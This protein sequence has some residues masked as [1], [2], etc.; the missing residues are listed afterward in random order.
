MDPV[1]NRMASSSS[2]RLLE[3]DVFISFRGP[4][5]RKKFVSHLFKSLSDRGIRTFK[6]D[7]KLEPGDSIAEELCQ[8]IRTSRFAVVVIS[9]TYADSSWCLDELRLIMELVE[10]KE[11]EVVPTFYE[12][13]PSDVRHQLG[14]F[15]LEKYQGSAHKKGKKKCTKKIEKYQGSKMAEKVPEW[16]K[17]LTGIANITGFESSKLY[18]FFSVII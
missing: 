17:A 8:A 3:Y 9:E 10:N 12:V 18:V 2:D 7:R 1:Q 6:D 14:S 13:K 4:D 5:T 16:K 15:S 11:M